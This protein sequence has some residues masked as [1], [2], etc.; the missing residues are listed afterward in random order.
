MITLAA[1]ISIF[2][3]IQHQKK[4]YGT[5]TSSQAQQELKETELFYNSL[6]HSMYIQAKP[7]L[8]GQPDIAKEID[9]GAARIDSICTD[10]RKD[11]KDNISNK[12]V[13][14]AL[15]RNYRI[16]IQLLEDM[17]DV[18]KQNETPKKRDSHEL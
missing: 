9:E 1:G 12:E 11:L 17:L 3:W 18:V 16:K 6:Y 15:I 13:I 14:E 10:I 5:V 4:I 8:T 7:L 2:L